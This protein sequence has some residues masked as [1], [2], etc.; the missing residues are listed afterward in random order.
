MAHVSFLFEDVQQSRYLKLSKT[1]GLEVIDS[2]SV[3]LADETIVPTADLMALD[4]R[5]PIRY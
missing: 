1:L 4:E 5:Y 2:H 3:L